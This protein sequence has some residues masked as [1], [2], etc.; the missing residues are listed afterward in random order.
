MKPFR[1]TVLT[2]TITTMQAMVLLPSMP[3]SPEPKATTTTPIS[4]PVCSHIMEITDPPMG[5]MGRTT[6]LITTNPT[7]MLLTAVLVWGLY[8][9]PAVCFHSADERS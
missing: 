5:S 4:R 6:T 7:K 8:A 2:P 9:A 3:T 1:I